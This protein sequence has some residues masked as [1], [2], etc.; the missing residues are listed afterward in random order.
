MKKVLTTIVFLLCVMRSYAQTSGG[1]I[2]RGTKHGNT[3]VRKSQGG[4][5]RSGSTTPRRQTTR[6]K[7][8]RVDG[9]SDDIYYNVSADAER[10][11]YEVEC[12]SGYDVSMLPAWCKLEEKTSSYF[13]ISQEANP[14]S[15]ER[16]DWFRVTASYGKQIDIYVRQRAG[17]SSSS[18]DGG[19][20]DFSGYGYTGTTRAYTDV[21]T[22]LPSLRKSI[23]DWGECKTGAITENGA[24]VV[25]YSTNGYNYTGIPTDLANKIKELN[26]NRHI[27]KDVALSSSTWWVV[28]YDKNSCYG[29]YPDGMKSQLEKFINAGEEIWSVSINSEGYYTIVTD[30]HFDASHTMDL[31]NMRKASAKYGTIYSACTT[32]KGLVVCCKNGC[33]YSNIPTRVEEKIKGVSFVPKVVKFTDSGTMLITDGEKRSSYYM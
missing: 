31:D 10:L 11:I 26:T 3:T 4:Q 29:V 2:K 7:Y 19:N 12:S 1:E 33:Y 21:A 23:T 14:F 6:A 22:A 16:Q 5:R 13:V 25:I 24:G 17:S 18:G 15:Y 30:K 20:S 28:V 8:L 32:S 9:Y 27:I